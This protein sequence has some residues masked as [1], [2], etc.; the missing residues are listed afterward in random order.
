MCIVKVLIE[1]V[2]AFYW[3][4]LKFNLKIKGQQTS[5]I[6]FHARNLMLNI[7]IDP[8]IIFLATYSQIKK[9]DAINK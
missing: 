5:S 6:T 3:T 8:A 7:E 9:I 1:S 2:I 4:Y